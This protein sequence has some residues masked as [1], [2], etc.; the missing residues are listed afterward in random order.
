MSDMHSEGP[1]DVML[2][3]STGIGILVPAVVFDL[4]G[5]LCDS[6]DAMFEAI[7]EAKGESRSIDWEEWNKGDFECI[8]EYVTLAQVLANADVAII[9]LTARQEVSREVTA[10]WLEANAVPVDE[11]L[12]RPMD[13]D[14]ETWKGDAI[15][16]LHGSAYDVQ[17]VFDDSYHHVEQMRAAGVPVIQ[18][19]NVA[20]HL[21]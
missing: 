4:D 21:Q 16:A 18:V 15:R 10:K 3:T 12:M 19:R 14:Y 9:I 6:A 2:P 5:V 7:E 8:P 20:S 13:H 17:L 11:L 1:G